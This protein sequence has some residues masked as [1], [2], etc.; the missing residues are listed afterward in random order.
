MRIS[1]A[2]STV[3]ICLIL[4]V[5][6]LTGQALCRELTLMT[7]DSFSISKSVLEPLKPLWGGH[8]DS[9]LRGCRPGIKQSDLIQKQSHGRPVF[10]GGQHLHRQG[11]E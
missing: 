7:H 10:R 3:I 11:T 9:A 4:A 1:A 2:V 8:Y 5:P 6:M